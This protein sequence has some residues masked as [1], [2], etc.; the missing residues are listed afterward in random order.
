LFIS[1]FGHQ[2][3]HLDKPHGLYHFRGSLPQGLSV[4]AALAERANN[5]MIDRIIAEGALWS[6]ALIA[7]F[8]VT[9]RHRFLDRVFQVN[10]SAGSSNETITRDPDAN[11]LSIVY[12]DRALVTRI[13]PAQPYVAISS[14]SQP[15]LMARMLEDLRLQ[16]GHRVLEVGTGTGY[17]AALL[18]YV[19][20]P[21]H[22]ISLD[23]DREVLSEA[24]DHL[25]S[26]PG[27]DVQLRHGDGRLGDPKNA[28]FDRI[29][30][31]AA[32]PDLEPAW[33]EQL[34]PH[35]L[36]LAPL[37]IASGLEFIVRGGMVN[38]LFQGR[39]LRPAYFM[40]LRSED[41]SD[42]GRSTNYG[43]SSGLEERTPPWAGWF[44]RRRAR[45]DWFQFA[46]QL[47]FFGYVK[48]FDISFRNDETTASFGL[49]DSRSGDVFWISSG[50]WRVSGTTGLHMAERHWREFLDA[51]A[52]APGDFDLAAQPIGQHS[53][54][55]LT[56]I[57]RS[58]PCC[59]HLW[60]IAEDRHRPA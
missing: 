7:A 50:F 19:V 32:T 26:F 54:N 22:V 5:M 25:R 11:T 35:G 29:M 6:P 8:R 21:H 14:S 30:V 18:A 42:Y 17:N 43:D 24:W 46:Q 4:S 20:G 55:A 2:P 44:D 34:T 39:L 9:P 10:T 13:S 52:P 49:R 47:A 41:E 23:V 40:P 1:P 60:T 15:S 31:T 59:H 51:G 37:T 57:T 33:L 16:K 45:T 28:P 38:G 56:A 58:G 27:R 48:G 53:R 3:Q 12:A 36:L